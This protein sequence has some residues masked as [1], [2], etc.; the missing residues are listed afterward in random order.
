ML[1]SRREDFLRGDLPQLR[2][3]PIEEQLRAAP[4]RSFLGLDFGAEGFKNLR[5]GST[6]CAEGLGERPR[7]GGKRVGDPDPWPRFAGW[8]C[9]WGEAGEEVTR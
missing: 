3:F 6:K 8:G 7:G 1:F 5:P 9:E 2:Q 4:Q